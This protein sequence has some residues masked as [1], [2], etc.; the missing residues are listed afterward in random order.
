MARP[1]V[2]VAEVLAAFTSLGRADRQAVLRY[3]TNAERE[4]LKRQ[5]KKARSPPSRT[6]GR[7]Q[8]SLAQFSPALRRTLQRA[9]SASP[10]RAGLTPMAQSA[11]QQLLSDPR[12]S[13]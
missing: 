3:L 11:L 9:L 1:E 7:M 12:M 5:L 4:K 6:S 8:F 13:K 2:G 10:R